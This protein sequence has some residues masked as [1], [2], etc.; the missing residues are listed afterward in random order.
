MSSVLILT[1]HRILPERRKGAVE[2]ARFKEHLAFLKASGCEFIGIERFRELASGGGRAGG[3]FAMLTFDDGWADN[4]AFAH[5]ALRE[6]GARATVAVNSSIVNP[7]PRRFDILKGPGL[8]RWE[9]DSGKALGEAS[10]GRA[11]DSFLSWEELGRMRESGLWDVGCHGHTHFGCYRSMDRIR[12]FHPDRTHWTMEYA[13]GEPP[14]DGAPRAG[15]A[16]VMSA[17]RTALAADLVEALKKES[18]DDERLA[19]CRSHPHPVATIET[20]GEFRERLRSGLASCLEDFETRLGF[21]PDSLFW[22]WGH[23]SAA[24]RELASSL[25]FNMLFTMR[26]DLAGKDADFSRV[27]RVAAPDSLSGLKRISS[28]LF[29]PAFRMVHSLL[30]PDKGA[31]D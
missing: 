9:P 3:R 23:H 25:G 17:P 18:S 29:N 4:L 6:A 13:L 22:P 21:K 30:S 16:S 7:E 26:K 11:F 19:L 20:D 15:F 14:F 28:I 10:Y 8:L 24:S 31:M 5:E 12:G 1:Y 27:P 2:L